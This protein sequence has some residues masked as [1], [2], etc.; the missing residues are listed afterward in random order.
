MQG[1]GTPPPALLHRGWPDFFRAITNLFGFLALTLLSRVASRVAQG[2]CSSPGLQKDPTFSN[3]PCNG[4]CSGAAQVA[5][6]W[7]R[8]QK[9]LQ[10]SNRLEKSAQ[11]CFPVQ[12]R[13]SDPLGL[14][15]FKGTQR[16]AAKAGLDVKWGSNRHHWFKHECEF[17]HHP[18]KASVMPGWDRPSVNRWPLWHSFPASYLSWSK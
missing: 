1:S 6:D 3:P 5:S 7:A 13:C 16:G 10:A 8:T 11:L 15:P 4:I 17:L 2:I 14:W 9:S 18:K 12:A